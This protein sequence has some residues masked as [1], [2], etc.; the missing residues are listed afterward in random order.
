MKV[1][2][3]Q[4]DE[5]IRQL[6]IIAKRAERKREFGP[7]TD[8]MSAILRAMIEGRK[9]TPF[10]LSLYSRAEIKILIQ[11]LEEYKAMIESKNSTP[12]SA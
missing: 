8:A 7:A 12:P 4:R 1:I 11:R 2:D 10:N 6:Y 5:A 3:N 9:N